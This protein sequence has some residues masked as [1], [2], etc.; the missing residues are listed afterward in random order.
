MRGVC[1]K[2]EKINV[3]SGQLWL[4]YDKTLRCTI[5]ICTDCKIKMFKVEEKE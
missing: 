4:V 5:P 1:A 3:R 2:C